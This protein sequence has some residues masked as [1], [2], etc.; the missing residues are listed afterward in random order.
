MRDAP[1]QDEDFSDGLHGLRSGALAQFVKHPFAL[2]ALQRSRAYLDEF[3]SLQRAIDFR[4]EFGG[5]ALAADQNGRAQFVGTTLEF[6][7]LR[8]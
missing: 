3:V 7:L 1:K 6:A 8:G 5:D 2:G 4:D